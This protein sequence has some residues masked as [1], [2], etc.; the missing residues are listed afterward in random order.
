MTIQLNSDF[1]HA[2]VVNSTAAP[3]G[4]PFTATLAAEKSEFCF[5]TPMTFEEY[6]ISVSPIMW[7]IYVQIVAVK[8]QEYKTADD[9]EKQKCKA[10]IFNTLIRINQL[11]QIFQP[12]ELPHVIQ[13]SAYSVQSATGNWLYVL[14]RELTEIFMSA[15]HVDIGKIEL[16]DSTI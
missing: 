16:T 7:R 11:A 14:I 4:S 10:Q 13:P 9:E 2:D 15:N 6:E 3:S 8:V 5:N 1:S 12:S